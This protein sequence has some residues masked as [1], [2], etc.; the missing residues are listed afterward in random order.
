VKNALSLDLPAKEI[1]ARLKSWKPKPPKEK[2][3]ALAKYARLVTDASH[4]AVTDNF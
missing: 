2:R 4:G 1:K 3:G